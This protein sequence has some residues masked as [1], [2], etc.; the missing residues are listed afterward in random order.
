MQTFKVQTGAEE[1]GLIVIGGLRYSK[2]GVLTAMCREANSRDIM[3]IPVEQEPGF[4][5]RLSASVQQTAHAQGVSVAHMCVNTTVTVEKRGPGDYRVRL[6]TVE[7]IHILKIFEVRRETIQ[8]LQNGT[9]YNEDGWGIYSFGVQQMTISAVE[10]NITTFSSN[11]IEEEWSCTDE[12]TKGRFK[13]ARA[14][15]E[16]AINKC[17]EEPVKISKMKLCPKDDESGAVRSEW[18]KLLQEL[19]EASPIKEVRL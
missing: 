6:E 11:P 14:F 17:G 16:D 2:Q 5:R 1:Q 8:A 3:Y 13:V 7:E 15:V 19:N 9:I 18:Q 10:F 4:A 12:T